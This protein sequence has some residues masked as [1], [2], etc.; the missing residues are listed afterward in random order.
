LPQSKHLSWLSDFY[1]WP[2]DLDDSLA[3]LEQHYHTLINTYAINPQRVIISGFSRGAF[4]AER[5]AIQKRLPVQGVLWIEGPIDDDFDSLL[6]NHQP[7]DIRAYFAAGQSQDFLQTAHT[8]TQSLNKHGIAN[9]L[10]TYPSHYHEMPS[11]F[12]SLLEHALAFLCP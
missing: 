9:H 11:S 1:D 7:L 5:A 12:D 2:N 8:F 3:D 4:L 10:E 6:S